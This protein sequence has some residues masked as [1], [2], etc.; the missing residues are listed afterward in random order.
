LLVVEAWRSSCKTL[1]TKFGDSLIVPVPLHWK[2]Q[3][4]RGFN[5][6]DL[7]AEVLCLYTGIPIDRKA[8]KR[9][10]P[11]AS[12]RKLNRASRQTNVADA[13]SGSCR[14]LKNKDVILVD[15]VFTSGATLLECARELTRCG[16]SSV[17]GLTVAK[18]LLHNHD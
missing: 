4:E 18:A 17:L 9:N 12:Q 14:G 3:L 11:T 8:L 7:L 2:R 16:V 10:R 13:F 1:P 5:Q 15:D 6:A